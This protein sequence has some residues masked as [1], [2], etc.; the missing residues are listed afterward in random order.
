[1]NL[2]SFTP[3]LSLCVYVMHI[4]IYIY[5]GLCIHI[6]MIIYIL[7]GS[8]VIQLCPIPCNLMDCSIPGSSVHGI[9]QARILE[10]V[11]ISSSRGSSWPR[12]LTHISCIAGRFFTTEP[13]EKPIYIHTYIYSSNSQGTYILWEYLGLFLRYKATRNLLHWSL[14]VPFSPGSFPGNLRPFLP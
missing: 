5:V 13:P 7:C 2:K 14:C 6:C 3:F 9:S 11:A 12:D 1:M 4:H 8:L 10:W